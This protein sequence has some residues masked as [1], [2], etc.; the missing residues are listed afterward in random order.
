M[1]EEILKLVAKYNGIITTS[2]V[3][4]AGISR[5]YMKSLVDEG[6]LIRQKQGVYVDPKIA[7]DELY[8][9][10]VKH[11]NAIFSY[12]TALYLHGI[13]E[14]PPGGE[15]DVTVYTGYN[16]HRFPKNIRCHYVKKDIVNLDVVTIRTKYGNYVKCY[17]PARTICDIIKNTKEGDLTYIND[18]LNKY[19]RSN[20][21]NQS[22]LIECANK[23]N[24]YKKLNYAIG[25]SFLANKSISGGGCL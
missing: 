10:Q 12:E 22:K 14:A 19:F 25:I 23:M 2:Q 17:T 9:F 6:L 24:V 21:F 3:E 5:V 13:G 8:I 20:V 7:N 18:T 15:M 16:T 4:E 1:K 11:P